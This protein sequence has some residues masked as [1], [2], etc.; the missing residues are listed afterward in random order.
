MTAHGPI[1]IS[2]P[3]S[4]TSFPSSVREYYTDK[5]LNCP[6]DTD[7]FI[8]ELYDFAPEMGIELVMAPN[9]RYVIDL[10]R[11]PENSSLYSD[12]RSQTSLTPSCTFLGENILKKEIP[13]EEIKRRLDQFYWPY[14]KELE[15][16]LNLRV[17]K[18][19]KALLFDAHSIKRNV[20]TIREQPFPDMILGDADQTTASE[21]LISTALK[22]LASGDYQ[23]EHNNPF[24]G[25]HITR[26]F[27]N[28]NKNVHA[29]QLE[30]SQDIYMNEKSTTYNKEKA[31]KV[32][33]LLKKFFK[34]LTLVLE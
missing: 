18:F 25:G 8:H 2:V 33:E 21:V 13:T 10:N 27:G 6:E 11:S 15:R 16:K 22:A 7:W 34:K 29:L 30:M 28:L 17:K 24:K 4:G 19:G 3:H 26:Y 32:R 12:G 14:Y 31:D 23:V 9:S 1:L 20:K 5:A